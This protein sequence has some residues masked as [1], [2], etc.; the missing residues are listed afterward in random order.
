LHLIRAVHNHLDGIAM[1]EDIT[2]DEL[3]STQRIALKNG[4]Y[5]QAFSGN[6]E[7]IRGFTGHVIVDEWASSPYDAEAL[8]MQALAVTSSRSDYR[9]IMLTNAPGTGSF[10]DQFMHSESYELARTHWKIFTTT[11]WDAYP[12]GFPPNIQAVF[13]SAPPRRW[14][15]EYECMSLEGTDPAFD[16]DSVVS[17]TNNP[18]LD[19]I[20]AFRV[21][22]VDPGATNNP[23]GITISDC[24]GGMVKLRYVDMWFAKP[25]EDQVSEI[26]RLVGEHRVNAV[27][28]DQ[29]V[30]GLSIVQ[31]LRK[32]LGEGF[33]RGVSV[34][35]NSRNTAYQVLSKLLVD[36]RIS[37][38]DNKFLIDDLNTASLD[39]RGRLILPRRPMGKHE[40]HCDA[41]DSLLMAMPYA[42][43]RGASTSQQASH[44][45]QTKRMMMEELQVAVDRSSSSYR[46]W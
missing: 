8:Y 11:I 22:C 14:A 32:R 44:A 34:N 41:L 28:C 16:Y 18:Y 26:V 10:V 3:D 17:C 19:D 46:G 37:V 25:L 2:H 31:S 42:H 15:R 33:V 35:T 45:Q 36:K 9:I 39:D 29:G 21:L 6:P 1:V 30:F 23:T 27:V 13:E 38:V 24:G 7:S 20:Q 12:N 5:I 43:D 4:N 40:M